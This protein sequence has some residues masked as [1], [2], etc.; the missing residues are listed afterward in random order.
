MCSVHK[1]QPLELNLRSL[2]LHSQLAAC[3]A[4]SAQSDAALADEYMQKRVESLQKAIRGAGAG[5]GA[6]LPAAFIENSSHCQT[7]DDDEKVIGPNKDRRW[8][9]ELMTQVS[10]VVVHST[11]VWQLCC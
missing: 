5:K 11:V 2:E 7:N 6:T 9:P 4:C 1:Q 10:R 3:N 8:L